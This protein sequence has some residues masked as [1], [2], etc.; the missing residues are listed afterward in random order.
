M[1][2][3]I[4]VIMALLMVA[5]GL[6]VL[7]TINHPFIGMG[8]LLGSLIP[9]VIAFYHWEKEQRALGIPV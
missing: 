7:A 3:D 1:F 2:R 9:A 4:L 8:F 5:F 6:V